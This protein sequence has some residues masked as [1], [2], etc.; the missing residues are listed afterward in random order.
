MNILYRYIARQFLFN[1]FM[2]FVVVC[3]LYVLLDLILNFDEFAKL[4]ESAEGAGLSHLFGKMGAYYWPRVFMLYGYM[5]GLLPVGAAGFTLAAMVRNRELVAVLAGG[6]SMYRVAAPILMFT[7]LA[8]VVMVANQE[9]VLPALAY[10]LTEGH[11]QLRRDGAKLKSL[12]FLRDGQG[13]LFSCKSY[14]FE[15]QTMNGVTI[16]QR[17]HVGN[18]LYDRAVVRIS[19]TQALWDEQRGG[20][21]LI[22]GKA[23]RSYTEPV[24]RAETFQT[25]RTD[26]EDFIHSDLSPDTIMLREKE[27]FRQML[28]TWQV[29]QLIEQPGAVS[30]QLPDLLRLRHSRFSMVVV[31]M[32]IVMMGLPYFLLR[33]PEPLLLPAIRAAML[34]VPAWA[35]GFVM[36]Q[37]SVE[38]LPPAAIAWLPVAIYLPIAFYKM[39]TVET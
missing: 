19:A 3:S 17:A 9:L 22:G 1:M 2:L 15:S 11:T 28:S 16:L 39:D 6:L 4:G 25:Q 8:N 20:W 12:T 14:D 26:D 23:I 5:V 36:H 31:N 18:G 38:T 35:G 24:A 32:L 30:T 10:R 34:C 29:T 33:S 7:F 37:I 21:E 13:A 27:R